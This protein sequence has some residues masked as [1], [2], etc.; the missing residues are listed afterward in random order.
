MKK[1]I[2]FIFCM[3]SC[4]S[5]SVP[6]TKM[7]IPRQARQYNAEATQ[8]LQDQMT[9]ILKLLND[10]KTA[11]HKVQATTLNEIKTLIEAKE[12]DPNTKVHIKTAFGGEQDVSFFA[13]ISTLWLSVEES[14]YY[15][16]KDII[17]TA[18]QH[19]MNMGVE[20][21]NYML[22]EMLRTIVGD[23]PDAISEIINATADLQQR[24]QNFNTVKKMLN[25]IIDQGK[26]QIKAIESK[27]DKMRKTIEAIE[28]K[29]R[30]AAAVVN[31]K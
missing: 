10:M 29:Q 17:K 23:S 27:N 20:P 25:D 19:G 4:I 14:D 30:A 31:I 16:L 2:I 24:E 5:G 15:L 11:M 13:F 28:S 6:Q 22:I 12:A 1:A 18:L 26:N 3:S 9:T 8:K 21:N 7:L